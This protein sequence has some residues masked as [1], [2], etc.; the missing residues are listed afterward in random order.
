MKGHA[1]VLKTYPRREDDLLCDLL[2]REWGRIWAFARSAR[3][4]RRRFGTLLNPMNILEILLEK[5]MYLKECNLVLP[6]IH[7]QSDLGTLG[8]AFYLLEAIRAMTPE[9]PEEGRYDLLSAS[10]QSLDRG[11]PPERVRTA[12][13]RDLLKISGL[14]PR[15]GA[16]LRC[17]RRE[18]VS[19]FVYREGGVFCPRCLPPSWRAPHVE[20]ERVR[21]GEE[22]RIFTP[23]LEYCMERRPVSRT[24]CQNPNGASPNGAG[25]P[26]S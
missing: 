18:T 24:L 4:S 6:L 10:L 9:G 8:T 13:C 26:D 20:S 3:K 11:I 1:I 16:C 17:N 22:E 19:F 7:L 21:R 25:P 2:T 12:F 5:G 15:L 23:F 14:E